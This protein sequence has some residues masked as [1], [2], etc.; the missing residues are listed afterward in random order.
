MSRSIPSPSTRAPLRD[1]LRAISRSI[2]RNI[3]CN[4]P[5]VATNIPSIEL[6]IACAEGAWYVT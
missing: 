4:I 5:S 6:G 1:M 2:P 3:Q